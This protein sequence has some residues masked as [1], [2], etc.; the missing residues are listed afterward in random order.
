MVCIQN[1]MASPEDLATWAKN[2]SAAGS[3]SSQKPR[4]TQIQ[5]AVDMMYVYLILQKHLL[6]YTN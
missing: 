2:E 5:N 4:E 1:R 6:L 3:G